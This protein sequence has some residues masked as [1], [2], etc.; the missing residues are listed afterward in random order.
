MQS[1]GWEIGRAS[2]LEKKFSIEGPSSITGSNLW[3]IGHLNKK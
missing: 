3:T 1:V 2:G